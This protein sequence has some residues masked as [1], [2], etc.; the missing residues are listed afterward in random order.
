M[1]DMA[2]R[3]LPRMLERIGPPAILDSLVGLALQD[4]RELFD[5]R[6]EATGE[7]V[8][9]VCVAVV[10]DYRGNR[11]EQA[12]CRCDKR[13]GNTRRHAPQR[14]LLH[15]SE[16]TQRIHDPPYRAEQTDIRTDRAHRVE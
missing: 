7:T 16:A 13:L 1:S 15:V 2:R 14:G 12:D 11:G 4:I 8:D 9:I 3:E 6:F 10:R 5:K